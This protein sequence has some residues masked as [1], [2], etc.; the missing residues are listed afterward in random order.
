MKLV[1][2]F[3]AFVTLNIFN[4]AS[5]CPEFVPVCSFSTATSVTFVV[6]FVATSFVFKDFPPSTFAFWLF[7]HTSFKRV[8]A[9]V[10]SCYRQAGEQGDDIAG[11]QGQGFDTGHAAWDI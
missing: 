10:T 2:A 11:A 7:N 3:V 6:A 5:V 9:R 8:I 4:N 1:T